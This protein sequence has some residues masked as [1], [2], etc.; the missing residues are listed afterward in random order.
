LREASPIPKVKTSFSI[1]ASSA[2][3]L[4]GCDSSAEVETQAEGEEMTDQPTAAR[5]VLRKGAVHGQWMVWDRHVRGP[6]R[7]RRGFAAGLLEEQARKIIQD[8][9]QAHGEQ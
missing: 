9:R 3:E 7:L 5:F 2:G 4:S 6:A 1:V 8:L